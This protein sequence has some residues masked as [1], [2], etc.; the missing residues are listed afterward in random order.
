MSGGRAG[1]KANI[2]EIAAHTSLAHCMTHR[3]ALVTRGLTDVLSLVIKIMNFIKVQ[4][5]KACL[6]VML[7]AEMGAEHNAL[8]FHTEVR[9]LSRGKVLQHVYELR[10]EVC[11]FLVVLN[12][13]NADTLCD[14]RWFMLLAYLADLFDK[15]NSLNVSLQGVESTIFDLHNKI[16]AFKRKIDLWKTK[17][18]TSL[19]VPCLWLTDTFEETESELLVQQHSIKKHLTSLRASLDHYFPEGNASLND[20]IIQP[21]LVEEVTSSQIVPSLKQDPGEAD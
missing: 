3:K 9:W 18:K 11:L 12:F 7:C 6:F 5:T 2:F 1:L 20:W 15:L 17:I 16:L 21:F 8:L 10:N 4:P 14:P 19:S 13:N